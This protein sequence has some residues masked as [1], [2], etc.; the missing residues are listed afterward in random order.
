M[1]NQR[2]SVLALYKRV[3]LQ[4]RPYWLHL[5]LLVFLGLFAAPI[6]LL[7]PLPLKI[8]VD[9]VIGSEPLP[10]FLRIVVPTFMT[11]TKG[12]IVGFSVF[13][14]L[15]VALLNQLHRLAMWWLNEY[16]S[17]QMALHFRSLLFQQAQRLSLTYHD[18]HGIADATYH[19]QYDAPAMQ[20]IT[21]WGLIPTVSALFTLFGMVFVTARISLELALIALAVSP[22]FLLLT[23][24]YSRKLW[25]RW[26]RVKDLETSTLSVVQ[27]VLSAIRVVMAFGQESRELDRFVHHSQSGLGERLRVVLTQSSF[28]LFVGLTLGAGTALDLLIGWHQV[29]AG[30]LTLGELL[31]VMAYLTQLY[32]P[33]QQIGQQI[34]SQQESLASAERAFTFL[35]E[36]SVIV[37]R[38]GAK[39]LARAQGAVAFRHVAFAYREGHPVLCDINF[40]VAPG[41]R[42]GIAGPSGAGKTTL[43]SLL[44]RFY[45]PTAGA[46]L[47]DG[48]D[49]RDY[50]LHDLRNQFAIVLQEPLLFSTSVA[51]NIAYAQ[52]HATMEAIVAAAQAA[53]A[54]DF[55]A[56]LQQG[57][58]TPVGDRGMQLSGG[59]R[60]R[61]AL[62]RAFLKDAPILILDEPTSSVDIRTEAAIMEALER[63]TENRTSF[64]ITHRLTTLK[65]CDVLLKMEDG[66]LKQ[67][68]SISQEG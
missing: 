63:L 8:V 45:D 9:S 58:E 47:V 39:P 12:A 62:A 11:Q 19:V 33:L 50:K 64:L 57:Y 56:R 40:E 51:A 36:A 29:Q 37:E 18:N 54:H 46:I 31:L 27:E 2:Y 24:L 17:E 43:V 35:D 55:I 42:V 5:A 1:S 15:F 34:A 49:L 22:V 66:R 23:R 25:A 4:V 6:A 41:T 14:V 13:L 7:M 16:A 26:Q 60:Q 68:V 65:H 10:G 32:D 52:P 53:N 44:M 30:T 3:L 67:V 59:E 21:T 20:R 28:G 48:T 38:S 61:I